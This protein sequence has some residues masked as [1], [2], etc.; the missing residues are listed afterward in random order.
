MS[1]CRLVLI[2][3]QAEDCLLE[4]LIVANLRFCFGGILR[5]S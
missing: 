4:V 5:Q 1:T 3:G 2:S